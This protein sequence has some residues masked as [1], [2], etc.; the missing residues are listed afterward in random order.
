MKEKLKKKFGW[1]SFITTEL[2]RIFQKIKKTRLLKSFKMKRKVKSKN[3]QL[4]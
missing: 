1:L 2:S 3:K 4:R